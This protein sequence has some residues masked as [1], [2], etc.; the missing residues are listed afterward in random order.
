[1][2]IEFARDVDALAMDEQADEIAAA[3][4]LKRVGW[5]FTDL[6]R[7]AAVPGR[8]IVKRHPGTYWL[9]SN[10]MVIAAHLQSLRPNRCIF[11]ESGFAGSKFS[12]VVLSGTDCAQTDNIEAVAY[13]VCLICWLLAVLFAVDRLS[14]LVAAAAAVSCFTNTFQVSDVAMHM[15]NQNIFV[16]SGRSGQMKVVQDDPGAARSSSFMF[17]RL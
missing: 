13:Q 11:A 12:T 15:T 6:E 9:K 4:G 2:H 3:A 14:L 5:I 10:E 7:D 1:M 17:L 16:H 8:F